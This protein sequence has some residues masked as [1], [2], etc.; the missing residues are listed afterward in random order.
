MKL[1]RGDDAI[2]PEAKLLG[3]CLN[4]EHPQGGAKARVFQAA[5]QIGPDQVGLLQAGLRIAAREGEAILISQDSY[6]ARYRID[7]PLRSG[8]LIRLVRSGWTI[9][10]EGGPPYLTTAFVLSSSHD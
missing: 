4:P 3:Y 6:G 1:P 5:L 10:E 2:I 9:R 8:V 7:Y